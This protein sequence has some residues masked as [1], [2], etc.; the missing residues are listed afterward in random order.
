MM[1]TE[2]TVVA[3]CYWLASGRELVRKWLVGLLGEDRKRIG[4]DIMKVEFRWPCGPPLCASLANHPGL[5]EMR[6]NLT[7]RRIARVFFTVSERNMVLLHSFI[8]KTRV[9][10]RKE[11]ML[12]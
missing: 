10:P 2:K 6:N 3:R 12:A 11:L 5:Y 8:R 7:G 9:T 1:V 4:R